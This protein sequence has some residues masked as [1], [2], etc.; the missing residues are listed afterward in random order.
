MSSSPLYGSRQ[1]KIAPQIEKI[2]LVNLGTKILHKTLTD[3][4]QQWIENEDNSNAKWNLF[5]GC[6]PDLI[7]KS[8]SLQST[9]TS[10]EEESVI[11]TPAV[12]KT[13]DKPQHSFT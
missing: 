10:K 6:K 8:Q 3:W 4:N 12:E 7:F 5:K 9:L 13:F 2:Y 1:T 11:R